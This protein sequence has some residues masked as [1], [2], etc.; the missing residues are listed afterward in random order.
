MDGVLQSA[1]TLC[2]AKVGSLA[3]YDEG[4]NELAL[5][6]HRGFGDDFLGQRRWRPVPGGL[7]ETV[8]KAN[9]PIVATMPTRS[10]FFIEDSPASAKTKT[11]VCIPLVYRHH[12]IG[13]LYVDNMTVRKFSDQE[14]HSLSVLADFAAT[15][16]NHAKVHEATKELARTDG[17][18]GLFNHRYFRDRLATEIARAHRYQRPMVLMMT[19]IDNFKQINDQHGHLIGDNILKKIATIIR[20]SVREMDVACRYGGEEFCVILPETE[21]A[22]ALHVAERIRAQVEALTPFL[23]KRDSTSGATV[24]IGVAAYASGARTADELLTKADEALYLAK[25]QGKNQVVVHHS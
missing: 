16:I 14:L 21:M 5:F 23:L 10:E 1:L 17:L 20:E 25:S 9:A 6:A 22:G 15:A 4:R 12:P 18:T 8:L 24:S 3:L 2:R 13:I 7:S 19:D 11:L